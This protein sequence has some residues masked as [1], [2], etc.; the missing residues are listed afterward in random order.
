MVE[1]KEGFSG[2]LTQDIL[3]S[4]RRERD[5]PIYRDAKT[6]QSHKEKFDPNHIIDFLANFQHYEELL[7]FLAIYIDDDNHESF[8]TKMSM[9]V[10]SHLL[11]K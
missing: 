3:T 2:K 1:S 4:P 9:T 6:R 7:A 10:L 11:H 8:I 5:I